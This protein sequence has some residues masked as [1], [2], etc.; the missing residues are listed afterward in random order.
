MDFDWV[1]TNSPV[2]SSRTDDIHFFDPR[3]GW[4]VNSNGQVALTEDG[5]DH[6]TVKL[7][8]PPN[9]P[10]R[11]YLRAVSFAG[12]GKGFVGALTNGK[13]DYLDQLLRITEDGG[14]TWKTVRMPEGS[15]AGICGLWAVDEN[16]V[17]GSGSNDPAQIGPGIV[18]TTDG[19]KTWQLIDMSEWATNLI[20]VRFFDADRGWVVGG[21]D[22]GTC[23]GP[24][25][26][27]YDSPGDEPYYRVKPVVLYTG[28]GGKTWENRVACTDFSCGEWGWKVFALDEKRIF[29]S[30]ENFLAGA[31]LKTLDGGQTWQ[32]L[33]ID[34]SRPL[35]YGQEVANANLE[36]IGFIDEELG[37][38]GGWA[39]VNFNGTYNSVTED[40]GRT[41]KAEDFAVNAN[42]KPV[43][44]LRLNANRFQF[45]GDPVTTGYCSGKKVYKLVVRSAAATAP[46]LAATRSARAAAEEPAFDLRAE[47]QADG[48]CTFR[49]QVPAKAGQVYGG[50]WNHFGFHVRTLV[51]EKDVEPG[52][53]TV[54]WDGKDDAGRR[55]R[56][57]VIWRLR[58]DE[59]TESETI[60]LP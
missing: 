19:G 13:A 26:P 47:P 23:Q 6:W 40:G 57:A 21:K 27:G 4:L 45:F 29:V 32:K 28:D 59:R 22:F 30:L 55:V 15:P 1:E 10:S 35:K 51:D 2:A 39:D 12:P 38:V 3:T 50:L 36:G 34:D 33:P 52:E 42:L 31:V 43:G 16:V 49:Y 20:D 25:P 9:L 41:W 11:P 18:K 14:D 8:L 7:T 17:Y 48:T 54:R 5:G 56:G 24:P 58:I 46:A 60:P 44:D 53:R 37:W